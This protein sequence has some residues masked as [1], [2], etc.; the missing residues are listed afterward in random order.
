MQFVVSPSIFVKMEGEMEG[1][2]ANKY[3][4]LPGIH[5]LSMASSKEMGVDI[6]WLAE[7]GHWGI[8]SE[9]EFLWEGGK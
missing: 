7:S 1:D 9:G 4:H 2:C 5:I 8:Y 6:I 3:S